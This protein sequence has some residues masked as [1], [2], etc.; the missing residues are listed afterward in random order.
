MKKLPQL[1]YLLLCCHIMPQNRSFQRRG[2]KNRQ[3][4]ITIC[5]VRYITLLT[6]LMF[7]W[8]WFSKWFT[9]T[10]KSTSHQ[11]GSQGLSLWMTRWVWAIVFHKCFLCARDYPWVISFDSCSSTQGVALRPILLL[12]KLTQSR[13]KSQ[14]LNFNLI[15]TAFLLSF[16]S[17]RYI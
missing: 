2:R 10:V 9:R 12:G 15:L 6:C 11:E 4:S 1:P 17:V 3:S 14:N 7:L 8:I 5:V 13:W 16:V